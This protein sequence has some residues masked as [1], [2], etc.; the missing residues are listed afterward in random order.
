MSQNCQ[1]TLTIFWLQTCQK[2][3]FSTQQKGTC[4]KP[5]SEPL[6]DNRYLSIVL[7]A[8]SSNE[9]TVTLVYWSRFHL[10]LGRIQ[11]LEYVTN[12]IIL[13]STIQIH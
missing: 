10:R 13:L 2:R 3:Q 9:T 6:N 5:T 4:R 12:L 11:R 1:L 8:S 7:L